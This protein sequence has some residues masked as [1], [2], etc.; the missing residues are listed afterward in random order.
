MTLPIKSL[1]LTPRFFVFLSLLIVGYILAYAIP[2]LVMFTHFLSFLFLSLVLFELVSIY[3]NR[4][5]LVGIR[6]TPDRFSNGD[7]NTVTLHLTNHYPF[8]VFLE[9]YD[10][11]PFPFQLREAQWK[12]NIS[13]GKTET[14]H[15]SLRPVKRGDY[16]FGNIQA[17][18]STFFRIVQKRFSLSKP[19]VVPVYP[20]Y[21]QMRK[22]AFAALSDRLA[23]SGAKKIRKPGHTHEFDTIKE[24][25]VGDDTRTIN[26]K[27]TARRNAI[28][29]NQFQDQKAQNIYCI[30]DKGR[31]MKFPFEGMSLLDYAVNASLALSYIAI[32]KEDKAGMISFSDTMSTV[33]PADRAR[34]QMEKL[35]LALYNQKTRY[36][37]SNFEILSKYIHTKIHQRS[38]LILFTNFE[39][40]ASFRRQIPY[41]VSLARKHVLVVVFFD[42]S[43][44]NDVLAEDKSD[45]KSVYTRIIARQYVLDKF[46][47]CKELHNYGIY[48][49]LTLPKDLSVNTINMY[50]DIKRK[51]VV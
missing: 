24:Y 28:M 16:E 30:I 17:Y 9:V 41:L 31:L 11:V 8:R 4:N 18:A 43:E 39:S 36:P 44:L 23:L 37:E 7:H 1:Y 40:I 29:V 42:N 2:F 15:Y 12:T 48:S 25:V 21:I 20:S 47:I 5:A 22:H 50:L 46:L 19:V 32:K 45:I 35:M 27:A 38:L 51:G 26:W 6:M 33:L 13:S 3:G 14:I 34:N 49:V 10:E